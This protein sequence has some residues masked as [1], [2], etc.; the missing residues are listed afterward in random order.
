[1]L[2]IIFICTE[3]YSKKRGF[4]SNKSR[5][6]AYIIYSVKTR[7]FKIDMLCLETEEKK[8]VHVYSVNPL[9]TASV[10]KTVFSLFTY[11]MYTN[12][13]SLVH[14]SPREL[15]SWISWNKSDVPF[16]FCTPPP[17][18]NP[19]FPLLF[20]LKTKAVLCLKWTV[21]STVDIG[22]HISVGRE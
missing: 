11:L 19:L 14:F 2:C 12:Y 21:G 17:P 8:N 1:M 7:F 4:R 22:L 5:H 18:M 20:T 15:F 6:C 9:H 10:M 13:L 16:P 3:N